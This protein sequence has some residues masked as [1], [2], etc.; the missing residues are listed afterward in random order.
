MR[1]IQSIL[2]AGLF[3]IF[4]LAQGQ[5]KD[6]EFYYQLKIY[7][8]N[9]TA[10]EERMDRFLEVAYLPALRK[11]GIEHIGVFKPIAKDGSEQLIYVFIP[12]P[13]FELLL[14]LDQILYDDNEYLKKGAEYINAPHDDPPYAR[15]E[16][17]FLKAFKGMPAPAL[18]K[19]SSPKR[20][21]VYELRSYESATEKI[22]QN[23]I[24]MFNE[25]EIDIFTK[26]NFNAVFYGKVISG[27]RMPN[28]MYL[29]TFNNQADRDSHWSAFGPL[30]KP[31]SKLPEH[32]DTQTENFKYFLY[33]TD[34]SD[35]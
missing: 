19:L 25:G 20:E 28:L 18:P 29:T 33:P 1:K 24:D 11:T 31:L 7:H 12:S 30:Y 21:R 2:I 14:K 8:L 27:S 35:Y 15:I 9:S 3:V 5:D 17:I 4:N 23:K 13:N 32:K 10:E 6:Q 16:S 26:L 34:Y 22:A